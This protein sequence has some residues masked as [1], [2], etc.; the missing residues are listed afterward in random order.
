MYILSAIFVVF[1][2]DSR[3]VSMLQ[4]SCLQE[5]SWHCKNIAIQHHCS[6]FFFLCDVGYYIIDNI[7]F[8]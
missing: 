4:M 6:P 1:V 3:V 8:T 5:L 2:K 7:A